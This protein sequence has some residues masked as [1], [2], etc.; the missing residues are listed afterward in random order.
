MRKFRETLAF[1][2]LPILGLAPRLAIISRFPTIPAS[3]FHNL[4]IFGLY[5]RI[6]GLT[7][8][9]PGFWQDFNIGLPLVLCGLFKMFPSADPEGLARLATAL[10]SGLLPLLP[11]LL[12]RGVLSFRVRILAGA[13]LALWLGQIMFSGVVAQDNWAIF[14]SIAL[15]ALAVRALVDGERAWPVTAGLLYT[16][17]TAMRA[18]MLLILPLLLA[19]VRVDLFQTKRRQVLAGSLAAGLGL[20]GLAAYRHAA[21][22][23]FSLTTEHAGVTILGAYIPGAS[24]QGWLPPY[25]FLASV[26]PDLLRDHRALLAQTSGLAFREALRRPAFHALRIA[27]MTGFYAING[28]SSDLLYGSLESPEVLP[29]ALHE[30]GVALAARLKIPLRIEMA[31]IQALFLAAVIVG[32]G[33]RNR[34]ILVLALAVLLKYGF[35][36]L[37]VFYGRFFIA[38][39]GLEILAIAVAAEEVLRPDVP[40]RGWLLA[41]ALAVGAAFGLGLLIFAPRLTAFVQSRDIDTQQHT[42]HF[43]LEPPGLAQHETSPP[44]R[45]TELACTLDRGLLVELL[46]PSSATIRILPREPVP[47]DKAVAVCELN[48]AGEPRPL[49]L[50]VFDAYAA[51]GLPGRLAQRV[52]VDG[53]EVFS[54]DMAQTP[55]S[56]WANIPL[57][58]VGM[59]TKRKVAIEVKAIHPTPGED[60][61]FAAL[62]RFRLARSS[63]VLNLAMD[64]PAAQS[65]IYP[66]FASAGAASAVDGNTDGIF[67]HGSVTATNLDPHAWWEVDLGASMPIGSIALWNRTDCCSERLTDYWVF[68]SATP[69]RSTD[70][71]ATLAS[72]A[73]TWSSHQTAAPHPYIRIPASGAEGRYVRVELTGTGYLSLAE[74]RVFGQ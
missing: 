23:R 1:V 52:E 8:N 7:A 42:Y 66:G 69:F 64:K 70:T 22:G 41:R 49:V 61:G 60:W 59:G 10:V 63:P 48:G 67:G 35:H 31:A 37:V 13:A 68:V 24:F 18:D 54:H 16:A 21:T 4:I 72:R 56:G 43:F 38:A 44:N 5:L 29:A 55:W 71:P 25:P 57:G 32:F 65:S 26:R 45:Y 73:G 34:A 62:A 6:H 39:T 33:R 30:R 9:P 27:A 28:E 15:G 58:Y 46:P 20:F 53:A 19:A 14:P 51:G 11:F 3:D 2:L 17:A 74:V 12:W 50:Q 36:V 40:G 47:G